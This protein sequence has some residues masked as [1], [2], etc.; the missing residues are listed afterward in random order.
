MIRRGINRRR[1]RL[2]LLLLALIPAACVDS[3]E[4]SSTA[5]TLGSEQAA[6]GSVDTAPAPAEEWS[7]ETPGGPPLTAMASVA[8]IRQAVEETHGRTSDVAQEVRRFAPFPDLP[9]M[10]RPSVAELRADVSALND[11][12]GPTSTAE[13]AFSVDGTVDELIEVFR[14]DFGARGWVESS[15]RFGESGGAALRELAFAIPDTAYGRDDV[16]LGF[17]TAT[18]LNG[19]TRT[20][21]RM[22][23]VEVLAVDDPTAQRFTGW[24]TGI[25]LPATPVLTSAG[26]H[27]SFVGRNTLH[28]SLAT[29]YDSVSPEGVADQIRT[30]LPAA[31]FTERPTPLTGDAT[32]NWVHLN[33]EQFDTA[34]VSTQGNGQNPPSSANPTKVNVDARVDFTPVT[35]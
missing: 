3:S 34:W 27:T 26:I 15:D 4:G 6:P 19:V 1:A 25:P 21:V 13:V 33:S 9:A 32:D 20:T 23:Y 18:P 28:L 12:S 24:T 16:L 35:P 30:A 8:E 31:G 7:T 2:L 29:F 11:G 5:G 10:V 17:S 14:A 22:R